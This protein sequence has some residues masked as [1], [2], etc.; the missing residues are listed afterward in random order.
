MDVFRLQGCPLAP[1]AKALIQ[2]KKTEPDLHIVAAVQITPIEEEP[3][4][5][6][7][8]Y[9]ER[10]INTIIRKYSDGNLQYALTSIL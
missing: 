5:I 2:R 3:P 8:A 10:V 7:V 9:T 6:V 4:I 1:D